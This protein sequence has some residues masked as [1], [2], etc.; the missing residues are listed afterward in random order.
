MRDLANSRA[1][2]FTYLIFISS[3]TVSVRV[4]FNNSDMSRKSRTASYLAVR[5]IW[6]D[7]GRS[8]CVG[9]LWLRQCLR[10]SVLQKENGSSY[11]HQTL[12]TYAP[13]QAGVRHAFRVR[14][15][16]QRSEIMKCAAGVGMHVATTA[17]ISSLVTVQ[18]VCDEW[19]LFPI[20]CEK[21]PYI[22][23]YFVESSFSYFN[24]TGC[25]CVCIR[26]STE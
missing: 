6:H 1:H 4:R 14:S 5:H 25:V 13:W 3:V 11:Q 16:G 21:H 15:K 10:P 9:R 19:A 22:H 17:Y 24:G 23:G 2:V 8:R 18:F 26:K 7:T 20:H 12:Y